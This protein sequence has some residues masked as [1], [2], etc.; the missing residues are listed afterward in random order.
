MSHGNSITKP[1]QTKKTWKKKI[2]RVANKNTLKMKGGFLFGLIV[3]HNEKVARYLTDKVLEKIS[4]AAYDKRTKSLMKRGLIRIF[5]RLQNSYK[6]IPITTKS[7]KGVI[8]THPLHKAVNVKMQ[9]TGTGS[10]RPDSKTTNNHM[11][12]LTSIIISFMN[13]LKT[14]NCS[15]SDTPPSHESDRY[16]SPKYFRKSG[17]KNC[18]VYFFDKSTSVPVDTVFHLLSSPDA[19]AFDSNRIKREIAERHKIAHK[20]INSA[21]E[22][23]RALSYF[24]LYQH[25]TYIANPNQHNQQNYN[26]FRHHMYG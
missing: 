25:E 3:F 13:Y 21:N 12:E 7:S 16:K 1:R 8:E 23:A 24:I 22:Y 26:R 6:N 10:Y 4:L 19:G 11:N 20:F 2:Q 17:D 9:K 18:V 15:S 14:S 5:E